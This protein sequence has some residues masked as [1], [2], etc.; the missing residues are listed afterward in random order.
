MTISVSSVSVPIEQIDELEKS[1][2]LQYAN[3]IYAPL[4]DALLA[5]DSG[6]TVAE[7]RIVSVADLHIEPEFLINDAIVRRFIVPVFYQLKSRIIAMRRSDA[8]L[9]IYDHCAQVQA[10]RIINAEMKFLCRIFDDPTR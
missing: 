3:G 8:S 9:W 7:E 1:G 6:A 5:S 4:M 2:K 10:A